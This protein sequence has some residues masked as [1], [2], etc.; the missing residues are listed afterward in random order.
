MLD[1]V[2]PPVFCRATVAG[3][4]EPVQGDKEHTH[5]AL[6]ISI[7]VDVPIRVPLTLDETMN[8]ARALLSV[9]RDDQ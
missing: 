1:S 9:V 2:P 8:V 5:C 7:P 3:V 4:D 6:L